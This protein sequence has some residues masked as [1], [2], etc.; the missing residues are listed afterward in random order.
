M[1]CIAYNQ[2]DMEYVRAK[3]IQISNDPN[4]RTNYVGGLVGYG[5]RPLEHC[6]AVGSE[7][8][9]GGSKD[10]TFKI[11]INSETGRASEYTG[12][13][14][15]RLNNNYA[16]YCYVDRVS[17]AGRG[18]TGG[19]AGYAHQY[20]GTRDDSTV[21][22]S[23]RRNEIFYY[24]QVT[25]S[26]VSGNY[27]TGG[28]FGTCSYITRAISM[29]NTVTQ[30][31]SSS[32]GAG[33]VMATT[34]GWGLSWL[35]VEDCDVTT[36]GR[37][38]GGISAYNDSYTQCVVKDSRVQAQTMAG[39]LA[40][41]SPYT[42]YRCQ[43]EGCEIKADT[44]AGGLIGYALS[45]GTSN[46]YIYDCVVNG[47]TTVTGTGA[48]VTGKGNYT[49]G[50]A[51]TMTG[52]MQTVVSPQTISSAIGS[53]VTLTYP[54]TV[55]NSI[56]VGGTVEGNAQTGGLIGQFDAG[57]RPINPDDGKPL[58]DIDSGYIGYINN[59]NYSKVLVAPVSVTGSS[60]ADAVYNS[61]S[62]A[63]GDGAGIGYLRVYEGIDGDVENEVKQMTKLSAKLNTSNKK[64]TAEDQ[65]KTYTVDDSWL[66]DEKSYKGNNLATGGLYLR[67]SSNNRFFDTANRGKTEGGTI[68][69]F[70]LLHGQHNDM[71]LFA[72]RTA[73]IKDTPTSSYREVTKPY[74]FWIY[75]TVDS[76]P[77]GGGDSIR[78]GS[79]VQDGILLPKA[80]KAASGATGISLM[81]TDAEIAVEPD[82]LTR[83]ASGID[84]LN[85]DIPEEICGLGLS[86][87][88]ENADGDITASGDIDDLKASGSTG[89]P[90]SLSIRYDY[91]TYLTLSLMDGEEVY[92]TYAI[93]PAQSRS[94]WCATRTIRWRPS[95]I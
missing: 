22:D 61:A 23:I 30:A 13:L 6:S 33:G 71:V 12:G 17:V 62:T 70:P 10:F 57:D 5:E 37:A 68:T 78:S 59:Q 2:G 46:Y 3:D 32:Y 83:Y 91:N 51:G 85:I 73:N 95:S 8:D 84:R 63:T 50:L 21:D 87:K 90:R 45:S 14:A 55:V 60:S 16:R 20:Y 48:K 28:V 38:A 92:E 93:D 58:D 86:W 65:K 24:I 1:G 25:N 52:Y 19:L 67:E 4:T 74:L 77:Y 35:Y 11:S 7:G 69:T 40:G 79:V 29:H 42:T 31:E 26:K 36:A 76:V 43:V 44:Y 39:G 94:C 15:G 56:I 64:L 27:Y 49:G 72:D 53:T 80:A 88:I 41:V 47:G 89:G 75:G 18:Y 34:G 9:R 81:S 66:V 54:N 82:T